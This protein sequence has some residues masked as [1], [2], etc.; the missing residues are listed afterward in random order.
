MYY[1]VVEKSSTYSKQRPSLIRNLFWQNIRY[2]KQANANVK[3]SKI[4]CLSDRN[5]IQ[6]YYANRY[7]TELQNKAPV[8]PRSVLL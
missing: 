3:T 1:S 8:K 2:S 6:V 4:I 7:L 5:G